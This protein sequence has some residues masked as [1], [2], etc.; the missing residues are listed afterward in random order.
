MEWIAVIQAGVAG[1]FDQGDGHRN[2]LESGT[3]EDKEEG[4]P[5]V[6]SLAK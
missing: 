6:L 3:Q 5:L 4:S 1:G 2:M